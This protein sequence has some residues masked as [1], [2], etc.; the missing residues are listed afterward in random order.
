MTDDELM[1]E[2]DDVLPNP[3]KQQQSE[4]S[5]EVSLGGFGEVVPHQPRPP[6]TSSSHV[7]QPRGAPPQSSHL[8]RTKSVGLITLS[9]FVRLSSFLRLRHPS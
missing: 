3:T 5:L 8:P 7:P 2:I 4:F 1:D 6:A 9:A